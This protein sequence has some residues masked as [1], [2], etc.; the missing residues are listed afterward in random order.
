MPETPL[1]ERFTVLE[2]PVRNDLEV[3]HRAQDRVLEREVLL[4]LP[5]PGARKLM[6][7][8]ADRR[9]VL[10]EARALASVAHPGVIRILDVLETADG[11]ILV[12]EPVPGET[13][14]D[15]L[16]REVKLPPA[17]VR[18][19]GQ[20]LCDALAAVHQAGYVHRGIAEHAVI[21]RPDGTP[22][23]AG[24]L[25]A[26]DGQQ[27]LTTSSL[28]FATLGR[29]APTWTPLPRYSAPEQLQGQAADER[30]DVFGLGS[31]L[32]RCLTGREPF[33]G[34]DLL[35]MDCA[36]PA[37][38]R[39]LVTG[40]P[41]DLAATLLL[42]LMRSPMRRPQSARELG[43]LLAAPE[44]A[45]APARTTPR[46][47]WLVAAPLAVVALAALAW[48]LGAANRGGGSGAA[49]SPAAGPL[50]HPVY[51]THFGVSR[52]LVIGI[53]DYA[54]AGR[55]SLPNTE[56]DAQ[57]IRDAL[58]A[59]ADWDPQQIC[60]LKG[61]QATGRAIIEAL[62][63]AARDSKADDRLL[64][65]F[66][67]HGTRHDKNRT[68]GAIVPADADPPRDDPE[69]T[70]LVGF[71]E[72][73]NL[74][75]SCDAKHILVALDCCYSGG[76][77]PTREDRA[78][79]QFRRE[80]LTRRAHFVLAASGSE[81]RAPDGPAGGHS[82]FA[83]ALLDMLALRRVAAVTGHEIY[84]RVQR[85]VLGTRSDTSKPVVPVYSEMPTTDEGADFVFFLTG[86]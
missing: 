28:D 4:K 34:Q 59:L 82:P 70:R 8:A 80:L 2:T 1:P 21:L 58:A 49:S 11:M 66:A 22:C 84:A 79:Q 76:I 33:A 35:A 26:R 25:F 6:S 48:A 57:A 65:Y 47:A 78:A 38:P 37:D 77:R 55:K 3:V 12:L 71:Q 51:G 10:R 56:R 52:A 50:P 27:E 17:T 29:S 60:L 42:C 45:A 41:K 46:R 18:A 20:Q 30:S 72:F 13:L 5:G 81:E 39:S 74:F 31:L 54:D 14:A 73:T 43:R 86:R 64:V 36:A 15:R 63:K 83:Q 24:F 7:S 44:A 40:V 32:Y 61:E 75:Q 23:L 53:S 67:G 85:Q 69:G 68:L 19:L 62:R 16:A 9:R